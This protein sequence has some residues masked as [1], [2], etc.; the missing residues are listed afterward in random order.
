MSRKFVIKQTDYGAYREIYKEGNKILGWIEQY[1]TTNLSESNKFFYA[2][3]KPSQD[4][5]VS[6]TCDTLEQARKEFLD[7]LY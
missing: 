4:H 5:Y 6:F 2:Y 3:G 7:N 1:P